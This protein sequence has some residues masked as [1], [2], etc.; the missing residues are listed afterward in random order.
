MS[1]LDI[2]IRKKKIEDLT[3]EDAVFFQSYIDNVYRL[4]ILTYG[5]II[6]VMSLFN[7]IKY[8]FIISICSLIILLSLAYGFYILVTVGEILLTI[9]GYNSFNLAFYYIATILL[10]ILYLTI[11]VYL[12]IHPK[13]NPISNVL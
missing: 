5:I 13:D 10:L 4:I 7:N 9:D 1:W 3:L 2:L 12:F 6:A 8:Y 11:M